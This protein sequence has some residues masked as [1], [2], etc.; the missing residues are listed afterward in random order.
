MGS[1]IPPG[2][3]EKE[4]QMENHAL[5]ATCA[6]SAALAWAFAMILF[7][8]CG[9]RV[10][11]LAL[12]LFKNTVALILLAVTLCFVE[13]GYGAVRVYSAGDIGILV[14]SGFIG[15]T[16]AD[17]LFFYSLNLVGV[18]I[19]AIVNCLYA[20]F[21]IFFSWI[22]L[23]E[24]LALLQYLGAGLIL[25]AVF[26]TS[27]HAPP[28]NRTRKQVVLGVLIGVLDMGL[29]A[30]GIV[31]AK[32]VIE[33]TPLIW[34]T[35]IRMAGGTLFLAL[36]IAMM[37]SRKS[38]LRVFRPSKEWKIT[39]SGSVLGAYVAL[40][41]WME[42]FK[43]TYAS[44]ASILNQT[45]TIF[46]IILAAVFL[47]E[48]FTLRKLISVTLALIGIMMVMWHDLMHYIWAVG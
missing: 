40:I 45:T 46:A 34:S 15:I 43:D 32:P 23:S 26:I 11:P 19:V 5:G 1:G 22:L 36:F 18:G 2:P 12:N 10:E 37:P 41:L 20:P 35:S 31:I 44:V 27:R 28:E 24:R 8:K 16:L 13:G 38:L 29:M 9:E 21:I 7:K 4:G 14:L 6:L 47:K 42:G 48:R 33:R 30:I 39:L 17:T 3:I 25:F